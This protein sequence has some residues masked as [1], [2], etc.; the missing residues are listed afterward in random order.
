MAFIYVKTQRKIFQSL[1]VEPRR[2]LLMF[3][4]FTM[5]PR[6]RFQI[7]PRFPQ[8]VEKCPTLIL[9]HKRQIHPLPPKK[10]TNWSNSRGRW[11]CFHLRYY[12][13]HETAFHRRMRTPRREMKIR[14]TAEYFFTKFE[15]FGYHNR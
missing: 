6:E 13:K 1:S 14:R 3:S 11:R 10:K 9:T 5:I 7:L 4:S 2:C 8:T 12:I 15:L